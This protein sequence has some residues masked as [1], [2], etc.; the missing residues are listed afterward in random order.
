[1]SEALLSRRAWSAVAP[2]LLVLACFFTAGAARAETKV[3]L[4]QAPA[5]GEVTVERRLLAPCCWNQT[6]D[7]HESD[8]ASTLRHE[9]RARLHAG[10]AQSAIEDDLAA[11]YGE[12]IR[13]VERGRDPGGAMPFLVGF[14]AL[15]MGASLVTLLRRWRRVGEK[16]R[17]KEGVKTLE[18]DVAGSPED[19]RLDAELRALD[20]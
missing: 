16:A 8:L 6:L 2:L 17:S 15:F 10:E 14:G 5:A 3:A 20:D 18:A 19:L 9:I 13:A 1:M 7:V 12:K 11:R 4:D